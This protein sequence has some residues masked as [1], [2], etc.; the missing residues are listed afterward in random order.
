MHLIS[1]KKIKGVGEN[2]LERIITDPEILPETNV[3]PISHVNFNEIVKEGG[4]WNAARK[5][6][7]YWSS[8]L[9]IW[10]LLTF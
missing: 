2:N 5:Y 8:Y 4:W 10:R 1:K 9:E 3:S 6:L 7:Q